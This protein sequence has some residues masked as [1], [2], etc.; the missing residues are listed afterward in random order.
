MGALVFDRVCADSPKADRLDFQ[1]L[2]DDPKWARGDIASLREQ[3]VREVGPPPRAVQ[4]ILQQMPLPRAL[5]KL[6]AP[7][8]VPWLSNNRE[9][10]RSAVLRLSF[11]DGVET[12]FQFVFAKQNPIEV[13]MAIVTPVMFPEPWLDHARIVEDVMYCWDHLFHA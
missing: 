13:C 10:F 4:A 7:A 3:A 5:V 11:D 9:F 1:K 8:W 2:C 6:V 12:F